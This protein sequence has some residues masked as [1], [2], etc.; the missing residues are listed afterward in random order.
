MYGEDRVYKKV[1]VIG[2]SKSSIEGAIQS[3]VI[4][5]HKTLDRLSWFEVGDIRGHVAED[6][7]VSEYQVVLKVAFQ[8]KGK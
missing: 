1:E 7:T 6:G 8:L 3:A 4:T 2:V 5:A